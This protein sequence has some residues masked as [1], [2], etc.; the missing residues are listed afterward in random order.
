MQFAHSQQWKGS[1][2]E[3]AKR[4]KDKA[5]YGGSVAEPVERATN[6]V[7]IYSN[8]Y[9]C[10]RFG[11]ADVLLP[12]CRYLCIV[13]VRVFQLALAYAAGSSTRKEHASVVQAG[14]ALFAG[15]QTGR[16]YSS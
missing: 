3:G 4:R 16:H 13:E 10:M 2:E 8:D 11:Q 1:N 12:L 6:R 15:K 14:N 5:T 9:R 7:D